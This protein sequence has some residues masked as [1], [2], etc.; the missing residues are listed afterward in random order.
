MKEPTGPGKQ[1]TDSTR[2][3]S[4]PQSAPRSGYPNQE[5]NDEHN[6][7]IDVP[8]QF[9]AFR[10]PPTAPTDPQHRMNDANADVAG[11]IGSQNPAPAGAKN[12]SSQ[13][14]SRPHNAD[15]RMD[16][17]SSD[18]LSDRACKAG[19]RPQ[20]ADRNVS[21]TGITGKRDGE[22]PL[23]NDAKRIDPATGPTATSRPSI[24]DTS[25]RSSDGGKRSDQSEKQ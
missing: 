25:R 19:D 4:I 18:M 17:A 13:P 16:N 24:A 23:D 12:P 2:S 20:T 10:S 6:L 21:D 15:A 14:D 11:R 3:D 1:S 9:G 5:N 7:G 22:A 8:G